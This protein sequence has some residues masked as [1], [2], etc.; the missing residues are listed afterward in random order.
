MNNRIDVKDT[1]DKWL[2]AIV[3]DIKD[4]GKVIRV[5]YKGYTAKWEEDLPVDSKRIAQIGYHSKAIGSGRKLRVGNLALNSLTQTSTSE[6]KS[7]QKIDRR[8]PEERFEDDLDRD[9]LEI[10]SIESDGNCLFRAFSHQIYGTEDHHR[11]IRMRTM[12][13]CEKEKT[14][15]NHFI[16]EEYPSIEDYIRHRRQDG[17]WGDN[18]EIQILTELYQ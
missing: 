3:V 2:E 6:E 10:I 13:Y 11:Y 7:D 1:M 17:V 14:F 12:D 18:L 15:F 8:N 9:G 5:H 4:S 16:P